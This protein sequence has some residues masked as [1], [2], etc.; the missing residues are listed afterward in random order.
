MKKEI[1]ARYEVELASKNVTA[2][3]DLALPEETL[4][5]DDRTTYTRYVPLGIVACI[6]PWN[7]RTHLVAFIQGRAKL[8]ECSGPYS[9]P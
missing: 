7:V 1:I 4:E 3:A 2:Y 6:C 5:M 8:A 9:S